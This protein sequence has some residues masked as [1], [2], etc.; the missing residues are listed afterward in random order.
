M[1]E[2]DLEVFEKLEKLFSKEK[3]DS[4]LIS[5]SYLKSSQTYHIKVGGKVEST[6]FTKEELGGFPKVLNYFDH[7]LKNPLDSS[8]SGDT[9]KDLDV[10][11]QEAYELSRG[12]RESILEMSLSMKNEAF[13]TAIKAAMAEVQ[14]AVKGFVN[15]V[16]N[17]ID[18]IGKSIGDT[19]ESIQLPNVLQPRQQQHPYTPELSK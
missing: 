11:T 14:T 7:M 9:K 8:H 15:R 12:A 13:E 17:F 1:S 16:G 4:G 10:Y 6:T 2:L 19:V 18:N 3:G 5:V